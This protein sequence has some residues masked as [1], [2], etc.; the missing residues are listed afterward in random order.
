MGQAAGEMA[1]QWIDETFADAADG[2]VK[3]YVMRGSGEPEIVIRSDSIVEAIKKNSKVNLIEEECENENDRNTCRKMVENQFNVN[4]DIDV[5]IT[6]NAETAM[7]VESFCM[8]PDSPIQDMSRFGIFCVDETDEVNAKILASLKDESVLRGTISRGFLQSACKLCI[9]YTWIL[10][11][12][13][14]TD[15]PGRALSWKGPL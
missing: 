13:D 5:I 9:N 6:S 14:G 8:S 1:S 4:P 15:N 7:G 2:E 3:V 11:G 12:L 10:P